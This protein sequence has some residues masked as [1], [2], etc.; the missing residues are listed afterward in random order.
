MLTQQLDYG[1]FKIVQNVFV[2]NLLKWLHFG[3]KFIWMMMMIKIVY[4]NGNK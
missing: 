2:H 3:G 1:K 4:K